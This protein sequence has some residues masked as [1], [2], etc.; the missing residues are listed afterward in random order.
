MEKNKYDYERIIKNY[1]E[2][3]KTLQK[4]NELLKKEYKLYTILSENPSTKLLAKS[5]FEAKDIPLEDK[6]KIIN[7]L[8]KVTDDKVIANP[9]LDENVF[10]KAF[11]L[12]LFGVDFSHKIKN[13]EG[14]DLIMKNKAWGIV[15]GWAALQEFKCDDGGLITINPKEENDEKYAKFGKF[16]GFL[17]DTVGIRIKNTDHGVKLKVCSEKDLYDYGQE[18]SHNHKKQIESAM[19]S[20]DKATL[21]KMIDNACRQKD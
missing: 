16:E 11:A 6:D 19:A 12:K 14:F 10:R 5:I 4:E 8:F 9:E 7:F 2:A 13:E 18:W 3:E 17:I 1:R 20:M 21:K 15:K